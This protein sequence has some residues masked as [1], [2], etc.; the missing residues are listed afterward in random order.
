M[1]E[2]K[3]CMLRCLSYAASIQYDVANK[4]NSVYVIN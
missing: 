4:I 1:N 2:Y 3:Y